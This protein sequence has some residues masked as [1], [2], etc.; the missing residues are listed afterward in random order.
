MCRH[1]TNL[2][3]AT[4]LL[5]L[6][7]GLAGCA[8]SAKVAPQATVPAPSAN[9]LVGQAALAQTLNAILRDS[10]LN[11]TNVGVKA[12]RLSDGAVLFQQNNQK[13][14]HPASNMK[15]F[16]AAAA[17][18]YLGPAF[19][20]TTTVAAD[21]GTAISDT[22][23]S[24]IYLIGTGDPSFDTG[25]LAQ[26][27]DELRNQGIRYIR[28][29]VICDDT[30]LDN[31][32]Y[33]EGWMSDDQPYTDFSP[34]GALSI[35]GNNIELF[36][37]AGDIGQPARIRTAPRTSYVQILNESTTVDSATFSQLM[38]D[39]LDR[40]EP[41]SI[42]RRW[43][44]QTNVFDARGFIQAGNGERRSYQNIVE[45]GRYFGTLFK[46]ACLRSDLHIAGNITLDAAPENATTLAVHYSDPMATLVA[47]MNKPSDN[48]YAELLLKVVGAQVE[49]TPGSAEKG[50]KVL[51][52]LLAEMGVDVEAIRFSD[53]SGVSR[54]GLLSPD[55]IISLLA[56]MYQNFSVRNEF[57]ASLPIAGVDGT[58]SRRMKGMAA[59]GIVHAKTGSLG[60]VSTLAGY[61]TADDGEVLAFSIMMSHFV[62]STWPFRAVQD[63]ICDALTRYRER[64]PSA[65]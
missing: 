12:V 61:T 1:K 45:P 5:A 40:H 18:H 51:N 46:E 59:E 48:L 39:T 7:I 34:I 41:Y 42:L 32:R 55:A 19:R 9:A 50:K 35:N 52:K 30:F 56:N 13:L 57:I 23:H 62:G 27:I 58:L 24:D 38:S 44:E 22:L 31:E 47:N 17:L 65:E 2:I 20:F 63:R 8:G 15:L 16:T 29:N 11:A 4:L 21:S 60:G 43:R 53:G 64:S 6:V 49:G 33:G 26:L 10:I 14:F 25:N 54:Y 37:R 36:S 28:G 3:N